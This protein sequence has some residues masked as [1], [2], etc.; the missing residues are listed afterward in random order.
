LDLKPDLL[1]KAYNRISNS[2]G[3][4]Y[5]VEREST[6]SFITGYVAEKVDAIQCG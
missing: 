4:P 3:T 2:R 1:N 5:V 6:G